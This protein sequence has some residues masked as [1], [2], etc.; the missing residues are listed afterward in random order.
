MRKRQSKTVSTT[1]RGGVAGHCQDK[2]PLRR[3]Q[4]YGKIFALS[5]ITNVPT[6]KR[7]YVQIL[8]NFQYIDHTMKRFRSERGYLTQLIKTTITG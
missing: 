7:N 3:S 6:V 4:D 1:Q 2:D 8:L 5:S